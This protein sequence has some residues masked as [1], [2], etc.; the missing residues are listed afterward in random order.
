MWKPIKNYEGLYL[1]SSDG[2]I[3][4]E[5]RKIVL[6]NGTI[7]IIKEKVLKRILGSD[8]YLYVTLSKNNIAK[9]FAIHRLVAQAFIPNPNNFPLVNHKDEI[10]T[11]PCVD[12]LEWCDNLYN[13]NYGTKIQRYIKTRA[14]AIDRYTIDGQYIDT[15][16]SEKQ[17]TTA[18]GYNG[19]GLIRA[20]CNHYKGR[21]SAYGFKWRYHD[22]KSDFNE[23]K[24]GYRIMQYSRFGDLIAEYKNA[25]EAS[26]ET[27]IYYTSIRKC[28]K[29]K[30]KTA[31]GYIW[32]EVKNE[33]Y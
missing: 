22:D 19:E 12:N 31:G 8:G 1:V 18:F 9:R 2:Y 17:F 30:Q 32:K 6:P 3:K 28:A 13:Q 29:G 20:V 15:W 10:K 27:G 24:R 25:E 23:I 7:G 11:N 5:E 14:K 16:D 33:N 21:S 26:K 4:R